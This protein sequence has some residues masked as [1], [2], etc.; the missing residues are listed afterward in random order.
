MKAQLFKYKDEGPNLTDP[1]DVIQKLAL[2]DAKEISK[3]NL[4]NVQMK[5]E[6]FMVSLKLE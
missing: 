2:N 6:Q 4:N 5:E 3:V 1:D